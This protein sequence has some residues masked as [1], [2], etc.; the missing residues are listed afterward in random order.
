MPGDSEPSPLLISSSRYCSVHYRSLLFSSRCSNCWPCCSSPSH[1]LQHI[2]RSALR[3]CDGSVG[4]VQAVGLLLSLRPRLCFPRSFSSTSSSS[5]HC[6]GLR[7]T[8]AHLLFQLPAAKFISRSAV[9]FPALSPSVLFELLCLVVSHR[10][11]SSDAT[12]V[13]SDSQGAIALG[14]NPEHH[15]RTKH[16]DIQHHYVREQVA[17]GAITSPYNS[18]D[19]MVADVL[20]KPLAVDRHSKLARAM[21]VRATTLHFN[22][23]VFIHTQV[24]PEPS[25]A[26]MEQTQHLAQSPSWTISSHPFHP[27]RLFLDRLP[28]NASGDCLSLGFPTCSTP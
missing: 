13:Y 12:T 15:K 9:A 19:D 20:T 14:K 27:L 18:T 7:A 23:S 16:S 2:A 26:N 22:S 24:C 6:S 17:A 28:L 11:L 25:A 1:H 3:T 10:G 4:V 5:R 21:G 8:P